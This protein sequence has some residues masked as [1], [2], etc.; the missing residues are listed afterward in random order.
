LKVAQINST[1]HAG[2]TGKICMEISTLLSEKGI[3]NL[4]FHGQVGCDFPKAECYSG[5]YYAM[6]QAFKAHILGNYGFN[7]SCA[8]KKLI[9]HLEKFDPDIVHLHNI[10]SHECNV[11]MLLDYLKNKNVKVVWTFHDCWA[12][13][14]YCTHFDYINCSKWKSGCCSCPQYKSKSFFFDRSKALFERKK[15]MQYGMDLTVITPS[16][17]L[18]DLVGKSFFREYPRYVIHNGIDLNV[19]RPWDDN[20]RKK[21]GVKGKMILGVAYDWGKRKG[22]DVFIELRKRLEDDYTIVLVGADESLKKTLPDGIIPIRKTQNREELAGIYSAADVFFNPTREDTYP[23]VN[24][25]AIACGTP[26]VT[27]RT[28]GSIEII[29]DTCGIAVERDDI[30]AAEHAIRKVCENQLFKRDDLIKKAG[31]FDKNKCFLEYLA[32]YNR[33]LPE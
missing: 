31:E 9:S 3:D 24:M 11:G 29:D 25:E 6:F 15:E 30:D 4:I 33:L 17:W 19:F 26:V 16:R 5:K 21:L 18:S 32:L 2:S 1:C 8:T 7:S 13:T 28:G 14:A 23:T 20:F 22:L 10:H 12:F 27:F